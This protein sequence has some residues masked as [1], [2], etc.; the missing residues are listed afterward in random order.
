MLRTFSTWAEPCPIRTGEPEQVI[1]KYCIAKSGIGRGTVNKEFAIDIEIQ[2]LV[3]A[4][5]ANIATELEG[6]VSND[7][8]DAVGPLERI[9]HLRQF[10]LA[11][12]A[13]GESAVQLDE[14]KPFG[15]GPRSG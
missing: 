15:L 12:V 13:D 5:A 10:A 8:A 6:M 2:S 4:L 3:K 7:F 9:A 14:R 11:I 1:G